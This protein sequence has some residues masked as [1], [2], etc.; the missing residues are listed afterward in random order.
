MRHNVVTWRP[1]GYAEL[2][3]VLRQL[4][5]AWFE[6]KPSTPETK[7]PAVVDPSVASLVRPSQTTEQTAEHP[8]ERS[9]ADLQLMLCALTGRELHIV[10]TDNRRS[11]IRMMRRGGKDIVRLH[12]MFL[13]ADDG[14]VADLGRFLTRSNRHSNTRL[15]RFIE[16]N[17]DQ[18]RKGVS[19]DVKLR[20][21]G[22]FY[23]LDALFSQLNETYFEGNVRA[24]VTWGRTPNKKRRRSIRLGTYS[25]DE[26]LIR[27][28]PALD[29][30]WVPEFVVAMVMYHEMLHA[31]VPPIMRGNHKVFHTP[32]FRRRERA[33]PDFARATAWENAN[34]ARLLRS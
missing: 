26:R 1:L 28:H 12:H 23:D 33:H 14:I 3:G 21:R 27:I 16:D 6:S 24:R 5:F 8:A 19:R 10:I 34:L 15:D 20:P 17:H 9:R 31:V 25:S 18:I 4:T 29:A 13:R 32:E 2:M 30:E 7:T 11:V 22:A